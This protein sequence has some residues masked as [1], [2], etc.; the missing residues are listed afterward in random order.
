[1]HMKNRPRNFCGRLLVILLVWTLLHSFGFGQEDKPW[2]FPEALRSDLDSR[3]HAFTEAQASGDW[4][5]VAILLGR[6]RR[7]GNYMLYTP[8]HRACLVEEMKR[9]P[10]IAFDYKVWDRSFS[11]EILS[12]APGRRWWTL[13]GE[14][15]FRQ[16][17]HENKTHMSL[18]AYRDEGKWYFTPPPIDNGNAASHFTAEQRAADLNDKVLLQKGQSYSLEVVEFHVFMDKDNV[19]THRIHFRLHNKS[20]KKVTSYSYRISESNN[21]G[22]E[23]SATGNNLDW[24]APHGI[25]HQFESDHPTAYYWCEGEAV[26]KIEILDVGFEDGSTWKA[27]RV[28][29]RAQVSK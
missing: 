3:V 16:G 22:S 10:M 2:M 27:A 6:Y 20:A 9:V 8:S 23:E 1:M 29:K 7:G 21:D 25:S 17:A 12:T 24:N 28:H 15:T 11:S 18:V 26:T 13:V 19:M 4:V 5:Q 14:A